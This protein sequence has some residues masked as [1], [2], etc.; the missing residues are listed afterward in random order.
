[1][2]GLRRATLL[3]L[4]VLLLA[5][6]G[7]DSGPAE[8]PPK[9]APAIQ[10][11]MNP[12]PSD[13]PAAAGRTLQQLADEVTA[14]AQVGLATSVFTPGE[15]RLAFGVISPERK[16]LYGKTAVYVARDAHDRADGPFMAPADSLVTA[17]KYRSDQAAS[18]ADIFAAI[19]AAE[20]PLREAGKYEVLT[21]TKLGGRLYGAATAI[22]VARKARVPDVGDP[23]PRVETDTAFAARGN[24]ASID[25]RVPPDDM[26]ETNLRSAL[27]REPVAIVFASPQLCQ[28]RVCGPVVDIAA[29]IKAKYGDRMAFIHQEAYVDNDLR[30]G[31]RPPL[32]AFSLP[33]EPWLFTIDRSGKIAARL[34]GSFGLRA[35]EEAVKAAL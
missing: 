1:M 16:F 27:G 5:A 30:K 32:K 13:F 20:V 4:P 10:R 22:R 19:Y 8:P 34:E 29:Q 18:E 3:A 26:H 24:I 7:A 31:L 25:T 35:F 21:V 11:A 12:Q 6:C 15:N 23:A 9:P 2:S 28:S 17:R 33:S 14:Q